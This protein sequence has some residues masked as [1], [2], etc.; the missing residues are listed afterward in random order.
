MRNAREVQTAPA[1]RRE[2]NDLHGPFFRILLGPD[3]TKI[4]SEAP[5]LAPASSAASCCSTAPHALVTQIP[6]GVED[7][8]LAATRSDSA[9]HS[10][11]VYRALTAIGGHAMPP[12]KPR[13]G[14]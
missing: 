9:N 3:N 8:L 13:P 5:W 11:R 14:V 7:V 4:S 12:R 1:L 2:T 10:N 6:E